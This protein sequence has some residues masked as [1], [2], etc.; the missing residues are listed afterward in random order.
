MGSHNS[1]PGLQGSL[2]IVT[3]IVGIFPMSGPA[4]LPVLIHNIN[5]SHGAC[6]SVHSAP[7]MR[8]AAPAWGSRSLRLQDEGTRQWHPLRP[9]VRAVRV[10]ALLRVL[11]I[12]QVDHKVDVVAAVC[13]PHV[14]AEVRAGACEAVHSSQLPIPGQPAPRSACVTLLP[15]CG[16][17]A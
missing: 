1:E 8:G 6:L 7:P 11:R 14:L 16:G 13:A 4:N 10:V 15:G 3:L 5:E 17:A 9:E 12:P 2:N